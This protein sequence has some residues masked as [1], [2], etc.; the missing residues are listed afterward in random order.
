MNEPMKKTKP[1]K[2]SFPLSVDMDPY[3]HVE[4]ADGVILAR[5]YLHMGK[6]QYVL[7]AVNSHEKLVE[8]LG[9]FSMGGCECDV[10]NP[11]LSRWDPSKPI[12]HWGGEKACRVCYARAVLVLARGDKT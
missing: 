12:L 10:L 6:M 4:D 8:A 5:D 9:N 11:C 1:C 2:I 7:N 3:P